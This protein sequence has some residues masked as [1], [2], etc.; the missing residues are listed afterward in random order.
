MQRSHRPARRI[1]AFLLLCLLTTALFSCSASR[2]IKPSEQDLTVVANCAG[3]DVYYDELR[4]ITMSYKDVYTARYGD[5]VWTDAA[6]TEQYLPMLKQDVTRS[7]K[8]NY[9]ILSLCAEFGID[10]S[11]KTVEEQVQNAVAEQIELLGGRKAYRQTLEMMY[12]TDRFVR[13]TVSTD[14]CESQLA[15]A[16]MDAGL[17]LKSEMDFLPYALSDDNM[18][19]TYHL[20][21]AND[22]GEDVEQNR[23]RAEQA[24]QLL[25]DGT[26]ITELIG[27]AYNEDVYAPKTP[28]Y[29][30]KTEYE[31]AYEDAAFALEIGQ[32][33]DVVVSEDGFYVI[34][35]QPL[36][37]DYILSHLTEL[38]QRYQYA[39]VEALLAEHREGLTVEWTEYGEALDLVTMQ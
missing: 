39:E 35:R 32:I 2:P 34:V 7:L 33:S 29:F 5:D 26:P 19:A 37:E 14:A 6:L 4:Y 11:D 8:A 25:L 20:F 36:S 9:A 17:I 15:H 3:Y 23:Q 18:C 31:K 1:A 27:S 22:K 38:L 16:L 13:F 10:P 12:M 24:R 21:V 30:M 28:Y